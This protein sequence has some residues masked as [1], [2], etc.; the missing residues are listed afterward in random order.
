MQKYF[1]RL[2]I[3]IFIP[4]SLFAN[5]KNTSVA[6]LAGTMD[7]TPLMPCATEMISPPHNEDEVLDPGDILRFILHD[8]SGTTLGNITGNQISASETFALDGNISPNVTYYI[9][10]IAGVDDGTGNVDLSDPE[11]SVSVG[12]PLTFMDVI[13]AT[14]VSETICAGDVFTISG[15]TFTVSGAYTVNLIS[16]LGCDSVINLN[17]TVLNPV[18]TVLTPPAIDCGPNTVVTLQAVVANP[19]PNILYW[20]TGPC[21]IPNIPGSPTVQASCPGE[22]Q[23]VVEHTEGG[24]TCTS[25]TFT[26]TVEDNTIPPIADP[27]V[28]QFIE[29]SA[30]VVT[31]GGPGS[32]N[33][34]TYAY[35]WTGPNG[36]ISSEQFPNVSQP[37]QYCFFM[38]DLITL[39][40]SSTEC[41]EV[42]GSASIPTAEIVVN[43]VLDCTNSQVTLDGSGSTGMNNILYEWLDTNGNTIGT[44][45]TIPVTSPGCYILTVTDVVT[46]CTNSEVACVAPVN[47]LPNVSIVPSSVFIDCVNSTVTLDGSAS[48]T[49]SNFVYE[50]SNDADI[51]ISTDLSINVDMAGVYTLLVTNTDNGCSVASSITV[52]ENTVMP[53]ADAGP[54]ISLDCTTSVAVIDASNSSVGPNLTYFWVDQ[55]NTAVSNTL[56]LEVDYEGIFTLI[57]TDVSN[58]CTATDEVEVSGFDVLFLN[59]GSDIYFDCS[60]SSMEIIGNNIPT[61]PSFTYLWTTADGNILAGETTPTPTINTPGTYT[62]EINDVANACV[63]SDEIIVYDFSDILMVNPNQNLNC[64]TTIP[65]EL[66]ASL[67]ITSS[68]INF[69]WTT[70]DGDILVGAN[71]PHPIVGSEG[72]YTLT[73]SDANGCTAS[74]STVM[75]GFIFPDVI[76]DAPVGLLINCNTPTVSL[77]ASNSSGT[78]DLAYQWSLDG[79]FLSPEELIVTTTPGIFELLVIDL[80]NDCIDIA[81]VEVIA[82]TAPPAFTIPDTIYLTCDNDFTSEIGALPDVSSSDYVY[83]WNGPN[84]FLSTDSSIVLSGD[85]GGTYNFSLENSTNGCISTATMEVIYVPLDFDVTTTAADCDQQNGTATISSS[86]SNFQAD[87]STGEQGNA[88]ADLAQGWYS[89]TVADLDNNCDTH[90][91]FFV[92][93]DISCKVVIGGYVLNDPD[94]TCVFDPALE[95]I[96]CV[97]VKLEPLGIFTL[98]DSTGYYEFVVDDGNYT[99]VLVGSPEV[100]LQCPAPGEYVVTLNMNG[101]VSDE[102]HFYVVRNG[103]DLCISKNAGNARPGLPQFN[104]ITVCNYSEDTQDAV[105]TFTHDPLFADQSPWP[106][107]FPAYG[108]LIAPTYD[109]NAPTSTFSWNIEN[110][111]PGECRMIR[112]FMTVPVTAMVGDTLHTSAKVN[113]I[114]GDEY[115]DNNCQE[116]TQVITASY[117][118][119]D[120]RNFVGESAWGGAIYEDDVT[121]EY[122]IRFQN[123]GNDTAFTV[124]VRDTL[125]SEHL[126]VTTI[127]SFNSSH[128]M[129]VE[130]EDANVLIFRF[131][132]IMLVDSTTNEIESNGFVSFDVDRKPNQPFGT[133]I[134][135]QAA[136]Y[137]DFNAPVITNELVNILTEST[138]IFSPQKNQIQAAVIP[139]ITTGEFTLNYVLEKSSRVEIKI[140]NSNGILLK[141]FDLGEKSS[142]GHQAAFDLKDSANGLHF[143]LI[144]TPNGNAV[145][146]V[147]KI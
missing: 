145:K 58:G 76:I 29:C 57:V 74:A 27:G 81:Q 46:G 118:P 98:T 14:N 90:Q 31:L 22:Y 41:V 61:D 130:F 132:N 80:N 89:V 123:V 115:P 104:S 111:Q 52:A 55:N 43:G 48:S 87:W 113:P 121:M 38:I 12:T 94:S 135:N 54:D 122:A 119:N 51:I 92:D 35:S 53:V 32:S 133:E 83:V 9:S 108:N 114:A 139:N 82:D 26:V 47:N 6:S 86:L 40:I 112:W 70:T 137:F 128:N 42:I 117:D 25:N 1:K 138:S 56:S 3:L 66:E 147:V 109:Y 65:N 7:V 39:C 8:N 34:S 72:T 68:V 4:I 88:I 146:K 125:D 103:F 13:P 105:A 71:T 77:D 36:F 62:L 143:I 5:N 97:M 19:N 106:A 124:V 63:V 60:A 84:N 91:N 93:E 17:L 126:D 129:T 99:V 78:G 107:I 30:P 75:G 85:V 96:E 134:K 136:I 100:N 102:N 95:G 37:G 33:T 24:V 144:K 79:V 16:T 142:G 141:D 140:Y 15:N 64:N 116:W 11:L 2:V 20:W 101:T 67:A 45:P 110:L 18:A 69:Q 131:E 49:G 28:D 21:V 44:D 73:I 120:K 23:L 50:W 127:R 59:L 10:A